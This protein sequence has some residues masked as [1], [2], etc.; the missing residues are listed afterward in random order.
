M[1][2]IREKTVFFVLSPLAISI[3]VTYQ[4]VILSFSLLALRF[5]RLFDA[6]RMIRCQSSSAARVMTYLGWLLFV[7]IYSSIMT[8]SVL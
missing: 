4:F 1:T 7:Y 8:V 6:V 2:T 3:L 5:D